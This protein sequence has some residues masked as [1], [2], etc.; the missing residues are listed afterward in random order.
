MALRLSDLTNIP[1]KP[2]VYL[3]SDARGKILYIGKAKNLKNRLS[4]YFQK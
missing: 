1:T 4:Q 2:G 3:F